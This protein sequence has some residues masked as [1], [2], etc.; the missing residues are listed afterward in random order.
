MYEY[1]NFLCFKTPTKRRVIRRRNLAR[2]RV[3]PRDDHVQDF[4]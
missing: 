1:L 4:C 3:G 2:S